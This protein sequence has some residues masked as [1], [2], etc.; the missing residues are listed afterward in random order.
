M[1]S[2]DAGAFTNSYIVPRAIDIALALVIFAFGRL[3]ARLVVGF[4]RKL[5]K[6]ADTDQIL[7]DLVCSITRVLLLLV[8]TIAALDQLGV[9]TT[10]M[11]ALVGAGGLAIGLALQGS[12]QN[13]AAAGISIPYPQMAIHMQ[14]KAA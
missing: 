14:E 4:V 11:V 3:V 9:N 10:S 13:F 8:V 6:R 5:M 1:E 7:I 12:L 2:F